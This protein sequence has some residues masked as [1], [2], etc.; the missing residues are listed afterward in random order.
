MEAILNWGSLFLG[1]SSQCQLEQ[2]NQYIPANGMEQYELCWIWLIVFSIIS[3][4]YI[5]VAHLLVVSFIL[6]L[7]VPL[8]DEYASI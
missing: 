4:G 7:S 1:D 8:L 6:G 5:T 2:T 3:D